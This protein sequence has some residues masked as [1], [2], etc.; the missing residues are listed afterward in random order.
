MA[1]KFTNEI[2]DEKLKGKN[3][4]RIGEYINSKTILKFKCL[5]CQHILEYS[6]SYMV[7]ANFKCSK[8]SYRNKLCSNEIIDREL[9]G[10]NIV[11]LDN[12]DFANFNWRSD[13]KK[14]KCLVCECVWDRPARNIIS[15]GYGCPDC[16]DKSIRLSND[17][18]D[19]RLLDNGIL[20]IIRISDIVNV[21]TRMLWRDRR[22]SIHT[23]E[24]YLGNIIAGSDQC[25]ECAINPK[26]FTNE[27]IDKRLKGR[28]IKRVGE[29]VDIFTPIEW[30]CTNKDCNFDWSEKPN[31]ILNRGFECPVCNETKNITNEI[32][33]KRL[34]TRPIRRLTNFVSSKD[35]MSWLCLVDGCGQPWDTS[36]GCVI[37]S[38]T[39]CPRCAGVLKLTNEEVDFR[40]KNR[41]IKRLEDI[42][43]VHNKVYWQ[44]EVDGCN[45]KWAAT[46]NNILCGKGC[47]KCHILNEKI[48][49]NIF[50]NN[51]IN[52]QSQKR[53]DKIS[54]EETMGYRMDFYIPA[55]NIAIEYNGRQ[56][57]ESV[58]FGSMSEEQSKINFV[59]QQIRDN[60]VREFCKKE[61]IRLIEIDGRKYARNK[62][63]KYLEEEILPILKGS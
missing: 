13:D 44:C 34:A 41:S 2:I 17:D 23:W 61:F 1:A 54:L 37:N 6:Y 8:C 18:V 15:L 5:V 59:N 35:K 28:P 38:N 22:C 49:S 33:D 48:I 62:L 12:F 25:S 60:Y 51:D 16:Y 27:V 24:G 46:P 52:F 14:W 57:Y 29:Y 40:I 47:P 10:R 11:R 43:G 36:Y 56:H 19:K 7:S 32:I 55:K 4:Q 45:T 21:N 20:N 3:I 39:G 31:H 9:S 26:K 58:Q 30:I 63:I 53:I 42:D 50:I